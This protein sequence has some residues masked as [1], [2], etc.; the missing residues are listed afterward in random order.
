[1]D[2]AVSARSITLSRADTTPAILFQGLQGVRVGNVRSVLCRLVTR[3]PGSTIKCEVSHVSAVACIGRSRADRLGVREGCHGFAG[4][5]RNQSDNILAKHAAVTSFSFFINGVRGGKLTCREH[6]QR[7]RP[8][9]GQC[10]V[11]YTI[12]GVDPCN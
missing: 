12:F 11:Q 5:W 6:L 8:L 7:Q 9:S 2:C 1:M 4:S 10:T 3:S